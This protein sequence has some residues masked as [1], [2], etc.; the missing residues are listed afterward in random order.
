MIV[1][2]LTKTGPIFIRVIPSQTMAVRI[3]LTPT[4]RVMKMP[5]S[6][7]RSCSASWSHDAKACFVKAQTR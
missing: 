4:Y 5:R 2:F 6:N 1:A 7:K 3:T